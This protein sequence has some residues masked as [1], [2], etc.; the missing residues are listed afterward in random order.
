MGWRRLAAFAALV[1][2][3]AAIAAAV[4]LVVTDPLRA[5]LRL[6]LLAAAVGVAWQGFRRR[7]A[8]R[9]LA[10]GGFALLLAGYVTLLVTGR[11][12]LMISVLIALA[13]GVA[14]GNYA[15]RARVA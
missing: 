15:I 8:E 14:A 12:L 10:F 4:A 6:A 11:P 3:A 9:S 2:G 7:G 1:L 5:G 13:L